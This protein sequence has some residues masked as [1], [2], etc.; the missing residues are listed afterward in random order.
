M[1][2]Y[3]G[4]GRAT[5]AWPDFGTGENYVVQIEKSNGDWKTVT[6]DVTDP[7]SALPKYLDNQA[8]IKD[9]KNGKEYQVRVVSAA[10][11]AEAEAATEPAVDVAG[12]GKGSSARIPMI[13]RSTEPGAPITSQIQTVTPAAYKLTL[14]A[15]YCNS[16]TDIQRN[17]ADNNLR[18]TFAQLG[19]VANPPYTDT[20]ANNPIT[21]AR[22]ALKNIN[23]LPLNDW[24]FTLGTGITG[25][26]PSD[27]SIVTGAYGG[28]Q[29]RTVASVPELDA[30]GS[31]TGSNVAGAVTVSLT[32]DQI[33]KVQSS[34][35]LWIQGGKPVKGANYT[36]KQVNQDETKFQK[37]DGTA[38]YAF[39]TLRCVVDNLNGDNVEWAYYSN[40]V[41]HGFCYAYYVDNPNFGTIVIKK[42]VDGTDPVQGGTTFDY[43]GTVSYFANGAFSLKD[44]ESQTFEREPRDD[45]GD[46]AWTVKETST[47]GWTLKDLAC[48]SSKGSKTTTDKATGEATIALKQG[49]RVECTYTNTR[50]VPPAVPAVE[51]VVKRG[52]TT[53]TDA[54]TV[55]PGDVL[56]YAVT[57]K[58]NAG[59]GGAALSGT[60]EDTPDLS[61][62]SNPTAISDSGV[63]TAP[64]ITWTVTNLAAGATKTFTYQV[65]VK[66]DAPDKQN[67]TNFVVF[68]TPVGNPE[69]RTT[70]PI[71]NPAKPGLVKSTTTASPLSPGS[72]VDYKV[73]LTNTGGA[74]V[75]SDLVDTLPI[76]LT[77]RSGSASTL[78]DSVSPDKRTITWNSVEV[79]SGATFTV[80]YTA[81]VA[82]DV[83]D[84]TWL[85]NGATWAEKFDS[86]TV[87]VRTGTIEVT[88]TDTAE[89]P[90]PLA[91]AVFQ[92]WTAVKD[93]DA[94][95]KGL[96][97]GEPSA[98]TGDDGLARWD[99]L[100]WGSYFVE[101]ITAP[102]G[103]GLS[104]GGMQLVTIDRD[105]FQCDDDRVALS[106]DRDLGD[107][108]VECGGIEY[109]TFANPPID[110]PSL[111]KTSDP[112]D[113][114]AVET[115]GTIAYTIKVKNEGALPLTEQ[116]LVDTLP[117]GTTLDVASVTPAGDTSVAGKI[118]WTF[119]L[120]GFSEK[121]FTYKVKVTAGF[122]SAPWSTRPIWVPEGA[123]GQDHDPPGQGDQCPDDQ[124][125][126]QGR[127]VLQRGR[128]VAEPDQCQRHGH[129]P[130]VPGQRPG[131]ADRCAGQPDDG[132]DQVRRGLQP[133]EWRDTGYDPVRRHLQVG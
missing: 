90:K 105:T 12:A 77:Y 27:P 75:T 61:Y 78:P 43:T 127:A 18:E 94:L 19:A 28:T 99:N 10:H 107:D 23:C 41:R 76:G 24:Q 79:G 15:R 74:A 57:V 117:T 70:N 42:R 118:T 48:T 108:T 104:A 50:T 101:E 45:T 14:V 130:L 73:T 124:L 60:V 115:G 129:R 69:D 72:A 112:S 120:G 66:A 25:G 97:V 31:A 126:R 22:E 6:S 119:D 26:T 132:P 82:A 46:K 58:N 36:G 87:Q 133:G 34:S 84:G 56:T 102:V 92:L 128:E 54:S 89:Q 4:D 85:S 81:D 96:K 53:L 123:H 65:T 8:T 103:Y 93:G 98:P 5:I 68:K 20:M 111:D 49:D 100:P 62:V 131:P 86:V 29:P 32:Q 95:V 106:Q 17:R 116:T 1:K 71:T 30:S 38:K 125:L 40:S 13:V 88:K 7:D 52:N 39:A 83:A 55:A 113:G 3:P 59:A 2:A 51:K 109:A 80:T 47:T 114:T 110:I 35:S 16:Y 21:P 91:G 9:L 64:K 44:G 121:T 11:L 63:F 122:G 33:T 67:V 37:A